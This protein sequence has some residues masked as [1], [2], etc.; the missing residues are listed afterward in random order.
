MS[1]RTLL[2]SL[3]LVGLS[4]TML[5]GCGSKVTKENYDKV[6]NGMTVSEVEGIL[7]SGTE[8]ES[9][10][11]A[12]ADVAGSGKVL[13]WTSGEKTI[14]VTFANDKVVLKAQKGL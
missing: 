3:L 14:T 11:G 5:S 6:K 4:V 7:G 9:V 13:E 2:V 12:I 8:K 1:T 10:A